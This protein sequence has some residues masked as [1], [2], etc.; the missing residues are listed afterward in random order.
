MVSY[1]QVHKNGILYPKQ[2]QQTRTHHLKTHPHT[3]PSILSCIPKQPPRN[4]PRKVRQPIPCPDT[5]S[6]I[7]W[8]SLPRP[9]IAARTTAHSVPGTLLSG[10]LIP[11]SAARQTFRPIIPD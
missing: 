9:R 10:S 3:V 7:Y 2:K 8:H 1:N 11:N 4:P 5:V 6:S